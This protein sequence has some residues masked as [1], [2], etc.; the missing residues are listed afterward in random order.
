MDQPPSSDLSNSS[1]LRQGLPPIVGSEGGSTWFG[2]GSFV[3][4]PELPPMASALSF[5]ID[6]QPDSTDEQVVFGAERDEGPAFKFIVNAGGRAEDLSLLIRD[7]QGRTLE[8]VAHG[9][10]ARA[11]RIMVVAEGVSNH[12][13]VYE[14]QPWATQPGMPLATTQIRSE[15]PSAIHIEG[16][17]TI[18][19]CSVNGVPTSTYIGR[20]AEFAVFDRELTLDRASALSAASDNPMGL[21]DTELGSIS[22]ELS[23]RASRDLARTAAL[24]TQSHLSRDDLEEASLLLHRLLVDREPVLESIARRRGVQLWLPTPSERALNYEAKVAELGPEIMVQGQL[25]PQSGLG[26]AWGTLAKWRD[27]T[28]F[29]TRGT[30]VSRAQFIKFV[31]NKLGAGHFDESDRKR[32]QRDLLEVTSALQ[33]MGQDAMSFQ[34]MALLREGHLTASAL[35]LADLT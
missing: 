19:G 15:G 2:N 17:L 22:L 6:V 28:A 14:L 25:R 7:G 21:T 16:P 32:W 12:V 34:M 26:F 27:T 20:L 35:G 23:D 29:M 31:R 18:A 10:S 9:S 33:I 8:T 13:A 1:Q 11:R 4:G 3:T 30:A 24:S 5:I